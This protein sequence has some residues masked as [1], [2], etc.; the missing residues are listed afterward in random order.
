MAKKLLG[1]GVGRN[2]MREKYYI[3]MCV[4]S[5]DGGE[6][7]SKRQR[8]GVESKRKTSSAG[9]MCGHT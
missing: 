9:F 1:E 6:G 4:R 8:G 7:Q 2:G 5:L 3:Y